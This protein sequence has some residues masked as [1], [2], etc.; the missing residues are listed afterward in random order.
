MVASAY[1]RRF[2]VWLGVFITCKMTKL[3]ETQRISKVRS[4]DF[5]YIYNY[6]L[7]IQYIL[8]MYYHCSH[9]L[10]PP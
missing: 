3:I 4:N 9:K 8:S 5:I 7:N 2:N 1:T 6:L 10:K